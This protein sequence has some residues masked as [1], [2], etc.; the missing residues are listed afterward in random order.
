GVAWA[1]ARFG[2]KA[3]IFM[4]E[5]SPLTKIENTRDLGATVILKG[6]NFEE[7]YL[8]AIKYDESHNLVFIHPFEDQ[9]VI[10]GQSTIG[11]ELLS[12]IK[13]MDYV[14]GSIGGGGLV[15]GLASVLKAHDKKIKIIGAQAL[16]ASSMINSLKKNKVVHQKKSSTFADGIKVKRTSEKMFGILKNIV[17]IP[18]AVND[19]KIARA[20]LALMEKAHIVAE[21]AGALPLAAFDVLYNKNPKQFKN[22]NIVLIICGGNIDVNILGRIIDKGL[23]NMGRR[24]RIQVQLNDEP[25][26]LSRLTSVISDL[27][28]N[29]LQV[30]HDNHS[31]HTSLSETIVDLTIET[32]GPKHL[33]KFMKLMKSN[34]SSVRV[35]D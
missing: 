12:Q 9:A 17:D 15:S 19:D 30:I 26:E 25:G 32:K 31:P 6:K 21:G 8:H 34:Y 1:A 2:I 23:I 28:A 35:I 3:I 27:E 20:L 29:V 7:S 18:I 11:T 33:R 4:P 22:K 10:A 24:V 14:I 16:G 5:G 13:K